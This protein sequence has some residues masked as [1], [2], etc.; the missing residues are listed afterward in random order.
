MNEDML[1]AY[2]KAI[3]ATDTPGIV[4]GY[5]VAFTNPAE[6]DLSGEYFT[7]ETDFGLTVAFLS[8]ARPRCFTTLSR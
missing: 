6:P 7:A 5:L 4:E 1:I 3:K 8:P 2:G